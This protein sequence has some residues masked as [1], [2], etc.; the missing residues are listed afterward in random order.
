MSYVE[1]LGKRIGVRGIILLLAALWLPGT[2]S[3]QTFQ[4][5]DALYFTRLFGA[6][7]PLPQLVDIASTGAA[8][9]F[10]V[11]PSTSSG[12]SWLSAS[13]TGNNCC[14]TPRGVRAIVTTSPSMAAGT[15]NGQ[16]VFSNATTSITVPVTLV[17]APS[18]ATFFDNTPGQISFSIT[19]GGQPPAQVFQIRGAGTGTLSWNM[20]VKT[21]DNNNWIN[22]SASSGQAPSTITVSVVKANLPGA[23]STA[24]NYNAQLFL[25]S[26]DQSST[27]T[28]PIGVTV[29]TNAMRQINALSFTKPSTGKDP[30]P[31]TVT[32]ES[33]GAEFGYSITTYTASG[34][35]GLTGSVWLSTSPTGNNCCVAPESFTIS[36]HP[37]VTL[38]AGT[39]TAEVVADNG[40][41][42]MVIPVTMTVGASTTDFFDNMSGE[43]NFYMNTSPS[44]PPPSQFLQIRNAGAGTLNWTLVAAT[45]DSGAWLTASATTGA[46]PSQISIAIVPANLPNAALTAGIFTANLLFQSDSSSITVPITVQVGGGFEPVSGINFTMLQAGPDPLPQNLTI[47]NFGASTGFS[48]NV[49]TATGG[50]WLTSTP[51]G[52]NCCVT[53]DTLIVTVTAPVTMAAGVYTG[54]IVVGNGH[55]S[56]TVPVTLTILANATSGPF[57]DNLP[58]GLAFTM[59]TAAPQP[60][61][62]QVFQ[63]RNAGSGTLSWTMTPTTFDG[64]SWLTVSATSGTAPELITV[65]IVPANLPNGGLVAGVFV[66]QILLQTDGSSTTIPVMVTVAANVFQQTNGI[67]FT[68]V[69]HGANPLPQVLTIADTGSSVGFSV[70]PS[71][72]TGGSWLTVSPAGNNCCVTPQT[73]VVTVTASPTMA[74]GIY[75]GQI[76][77]LGSTVALT[78]PVTLTVAAANTTFFDDVPGGLNYSLAVG[79]GNPPTQSVQIRNY[80]TGTLTWTAQSA[81]F[82]GGNWITLS[83]ASGTAPSTLTIGIVTQN[84]PNLGLVADIYTGQVLLISNGSSV[85]IPISVSV[86]GNAFLQ[87]NG[88]AYTM[89]LAGANPLPQILTMVS[90][91]TSF[92]YSVSA[93]TGNGGSW[94]A[95]TPLGTNCCVSPGAHT[96]TISAPVGMA[97]GTYT[98]ELIFNRAA[99]VQVVPVTLTVAPS[100]VP[101]FDNVQGQMSFSAAVNATPAS[102]SMLIQDYGQFG[103]NWTLTPITADSGNWLVPTVNSGTAP[104]T[105]GVGINIQ[106]LPSQGLVAGQF[107]GQLLFQS[108]NSSVS[109]PVSVQLGPKTFVQP[110]P[111]NFSMAYGAANPLTQPLAVSSSGAGIGFSAAVNAANGGNWITGTPIGANCCVTP[112]TTTIGVNGAPNSTH[113]QP[114]VHIGQAVFNSGTVA[115]TVPVTLTVSGTPSL[116]IAKTHTGN[117]TTGQTGATYQVTVTNSSAPGVGNTS[118]TVT[119]TENVPAGMT[120]VSM[121]GTGWTCAAQTNTCTRSDA[122]ASGQSYPA[123]TVTVNVATTNQTSL[124]NQVTVAGGGALQSASASDPTNIVTHCDLDQSGSISVVDAQ[125]IVNQ[126]L[127]LAQALNDLNQDGVVNA[128]DLQLV[129]GAILGNG[130]YAH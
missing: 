102:Q 103:L 8:M 6:A 73:L 11:T 36:P 65:G 111:L 37:A 110:A 34:S 20:T 128:V 93:S 118:G 15:Y 82:D 106:N 91:G 88:I 5:V 25:Q 72:A 46:A 121:A 23:G 69:Q 1:S 98:G 26:S 7:D 42:T 99:S 124:T 10:S 57:F 120:L 48:V 115:M 84:L 44:N 96:V 78:I 21:F 52:N 66:G 31:Q 38:S 100:T 89:P 3:A 116:T 108:A 63:I 122:L 17:I 90:T 54:E 114:G 112:D 51:T 40:V 74:A 47:T 119:V 95:V 2:I 28:I 101:F 14:V 81:T 70:L 79:S 41:Q 94:L 16:I 53:P 107:T 104:S 18:T 45:C 76:T 83:S 127:G 32:V 9:G 97:A 12:G 29:A 80:G 62:S 4:H 39:Y 49:F 85:T 22:V 126:L 123:I 113:V 105:V 92:G 130:C 56:M 87:T 30:L 58:G 33:S 61:S 13:P 60:P 24:G 77:I 64:G 71:T 50:S 86:G 27:V 59:Q 129:I 67:N 109:V 75:T 68:M 43:L 35:T 117:F 19:P 125:S 55:T